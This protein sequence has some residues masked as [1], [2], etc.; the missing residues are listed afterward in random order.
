MNCK[1]ELSC[2]FRYF[3]LSQMAMRRNA[4]RGAVAIITYIRTQQQQFISQLFYIDGLRCALPRR[5]EKYSNKREWSGVT[6]MCSCVPQ[7]I[8][9]WDRASYYQREDST[10]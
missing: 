6:S 8:Y 7:R 5:P 10:T 2:V 1:R 9:I 4:K 3:C